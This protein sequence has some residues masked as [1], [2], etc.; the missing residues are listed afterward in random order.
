MKSKRKNTKSRK[1]TPKVDLPSVKPLVVGDF[2]PTEPDPEEL[3]RRWI[4]S[5]SMKDLN[6]GLSEKEEQFLNGIDLQKVIGGVGKSRLVAVI[7]DIA[8]GGDFRSPYTVLSAIEHD[9][10][11]FSHLVDY[12]EIHPPERWDLAFCELISTSKQRGYIYDQCSWR[13][14]RK[15]T[16][17]GFKTFVDGEVSAV[18]HTEHF[19]DF[20]YSLFFGGSS[21]TTDILSCEYLNRKQQAQLMQGMIEKGKKGIFIWDFESFMSS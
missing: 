21:D 18:L 20:F 9:N 12:F 14:D 16:R 2:Q 4:N 11:I 15:M 6:G 5:R 8:H 10:T 13:G 3:L 1:V 17:R 19:Y 7:M